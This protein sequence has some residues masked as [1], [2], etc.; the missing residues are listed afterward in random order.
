MAA[1]DSIPA[2]MERGGKT[3][4][5]RPA[6]ANDGSTLVARKTNPSA[7][8]QHGYHG[9]HGHHHDTVRYYHYH[10]WG[11]GYYYCYAP[12][13]T[14]APWFWGFYFAPFYAPWHY[15]WWW[16]GA[17]WYGYW[18]WYYDPY[19]A[20]DGPSYWVTDYTLARMLE[21]EYAR[22][23]QDGYADASQEGT[24]ITEPV[25]EQI[26]T[27]VDEMAQSFEEGDFVQLENALADPDYLF[28]VDTSLSVTREDGGSCTL[29][30]GDI[31]KAAGETDEKMPVASMSVI[32]SKS[33]QCSAGSTVLVSYSDL[34][35]M[36]NTF[37][38][39]VDDGLNELQQQREKERTDAE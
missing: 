35:E 23:Y 24:P 15:N 38:Q 33:S 29:T 25:K 39:T 16:V 22:G 37:G 32:T 2:T 34:Q 27:Q 18:G 20:Y 36:L 5:Q 9:H 28:I 1:R 31:I 21:D 6:V 17:P 8:P 30:G 19:P 10:Y 12:Y 3:F 4:S 14:Y 7:N 13:W 26:R 11:S